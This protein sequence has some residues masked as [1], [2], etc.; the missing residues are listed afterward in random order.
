VREH[1][2]WRRRAE[3]VF[4]YLANGDAIEFPPIQ[5]ERQVDRVASRAGFRQDLAHNLKTTERFG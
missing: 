2:S 5:K 4:N 1:H 3:Q